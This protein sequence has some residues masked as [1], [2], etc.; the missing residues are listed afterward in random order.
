MVIKNKARLVAQGHTQEEGIDYDEEFAPVARIE[1]I[2]LFLAYASFQDFVV[3]QM[4]IDKTL[5]IKRHKDDILLVQV[6]VDDIIFGSTK[7]E[8]STEFEKLMHDKFHMSSMGELSFFLGLQVKQKSNGIFIS[9]DKY[10]AEVLKKFDFISVKIATTPMKSNKPLIKD[11]EAED[12]DVHLY[13]SMIGSL[14]YLIASRH[15]ITFDV[16]ACARFQ[17]NP[18]TLHLQAV[19]RIFRYLKGQPK[20]GLWYPKNSPFDLEAYSNSDHARA[21]LDMKS[22]TGEYV[23]TDNCCG[24]LVVTVDAAQ[25]TIH[26]YERLLQIK[27]FTNHF[28]SY[29]LSLT[30]NPNLI[31]SQTS[32]P[33]TMSTPTF[34][35]TH[36][37]VAFLEKTAESVGF[38]QIIGFLKS[39][40]IH[41]ALT[42][43]PTIYVSCVK[44]FWAMAIVKKVNDKEH[45]QALVDKTKVIITEDSIRSD[46]HFDNAEGT[47]CLLNEAIFEVEGMARHKKMYV[48][49]AH[50]KKIFA[51]IRRIGVGFSGKKQQPRRQQRKKVEVFHDELKD[52]DYVPTP[53]SDPLPSG[54]DSSIPNELMVSVPAYKNRV[55]DLAGEEVVMKTTTGV[56]DSATPTT[57]VT[58]DKVTIAQALAALRS[59]KPRVVVQEQEMN[60]TIP[61]AATILTTAV[62][63]PR[64]NVPIKKKDQMR[65]DKELL[66]KRLQAREREEFSVVKK[67]RLLVK[68]IEKRKKHFAALRAQEKRTKPSTKTQMKSQMS[69]YLRHMGGYKQSHLKGMSFDEIKELFDKDEDVEPVI[70]DSQELKKCMEIVPNDGDEL[71]IEATLISSRSPTI[72]DYKIHKEGKKNYFKIIRAN[73]MARHKKMFIISSHT[74]KIF[75]NMRRIG[76]SFSGRKKAGVSHDDSEDEDH[77]PIPFSDPLPNGEDSSILNELMVFYTSLQEQVLDLQEAKA[78]Q[79]KE[80]VALKKK[81][82]KLNKWRKSRSG[83]LRRLKKIG[84]SRRV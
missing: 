7:K 66:A 51:N 80:I 46:L 31:S 47:T 59:T 39:K 18:K 20:L 36:N 1:A 81:V 13:R 15:D 25:G 33:V 21:S 6:Y 68:L 28:Q 42:V 76:A 9:Q 11:K 12:V 64:A 49:S 77:V 71:L 82:S 19:K 26:K 61:V 72:I 34:A 52:E 62:P 48:I 56:K 8:L 41:Y 37:L 10:V 74:K 69:T 4:D 65:V 63:T 23:A 57:Y 73:G 44:Q 84:S 79:A 53:S 54:E 17:V 75:V 60:T 35:E 29:K 55:D 78:A 70:D 50:T 30:L 32:K 83:G 43:N 2:R 16:C 14:M 24:Q 40:R 27:S 38:E 3:Y 45:I 67:A 22:T 58:K 5:F